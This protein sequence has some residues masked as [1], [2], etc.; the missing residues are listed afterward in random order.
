MKDNLNQTGDEQLLYSRQVAAL[1]L[2]I[3]PRTLDKHIREGNVPVTRIGDRV[4]IHRDI[5]HAIARQGL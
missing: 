3:H 2:G 1:R 5:L 4:L